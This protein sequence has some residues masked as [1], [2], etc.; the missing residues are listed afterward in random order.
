MGR[1]SG[2]AAP[3]P[4]A[5]W[6]GKRENSDASFEELYKKADSEVIRQGK[7]CV[8]ETKVVKKGKSTVSYFQFLNVCVYT[9]YTIE[10]LYG[11]LFTI[12]LPNLTLGAIEV[13]PGSPCVL[14]SAADGRVSL[15]ASWQSPGGKGDTS[16]KAF[17][18]YQ[19]IA[20]FKFGLVALL[21]VPPAK[22]AGS[23]MVI[24]HICGVRNCCNPDH[25]ILETKEQNDARTAC[26]TCLLTWIARK[27]PVV[28]FQMWACRHSPC[29]CAHLAR[30][31]FAHIHQRHRIM[32]PVDVAKELQE[33]AKRNKLRWGVR[34]G[35]EWQ[36]QG[37]SN[38][39]ALGTEAFSIKTKPNEDAVGLAIPSSES[40][41]LSVLVAGMGASLTQLALGSLLPSTVRKAST[42]AIEQLCDSI[43]R[44]LRKRPRGEEGEESPPDRMPFSSLAM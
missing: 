25:L 3:N 31:D 33:I 1:P 32:V 16:N 44:S 22:G 24:S 34:S 15:P 20:L 5:K 7:G 10:V 2:T 18:A 41:N 19:V 12:I 11:I 23:D 26:H 21:R 36:V 8:A 6:F 9:L 42:T 27:L 37:L 13:V 17:F 29:C 43:V 14:Y 30:R 28:L 39:R 4:W 35:Q 40:Q 38:L